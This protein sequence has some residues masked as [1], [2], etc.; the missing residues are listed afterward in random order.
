M[1]ISKQRALCSNP[2]EKSEVE[3]LIEKYWGRSRKGDLIWPKHWS[4]FQGA[5]SRANYIGSK[6]ETRYLSTYGLFSWHVHSGLAGV[7]NIPSDLF[8]GFA[9]EAFQLSTDVVID[10][11][12][13]LGRELHISKTMPEWEEHLKFLHTVIALALVD[14]RLQSLDEPMRFRYIEEHEICA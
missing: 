13:I 4:R 6:W 3:N 1:S 10:T 12:E 11:Y 5:R 14:K 2:T 9:M 7:E 8:N